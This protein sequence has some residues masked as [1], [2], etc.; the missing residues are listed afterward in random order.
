MNDHNRKE[1][2]LFISELNK[3]G[4]SYSYEIIK[5]EDIKDSIYDG[6]HGYEDM[7]NVEDIVILKTEDHIETDNNVKF[8]IIESYKEVINDLKFGTPSFSYVVDNIENSNISHY[9]LDDISVKQY[10]TISEAAAKIIENFE[11]QMFQRYMTL[12]I[13]DNKK[14]NSTHNQLREIC[15]AD[16]LINKFNKTGKELFKTEIDADNLK[17]MAY[18]KKYNNW[19]EI[20][21]I[22]DFNISTQ[23]VS[24]LSENY[25]LYINEITDLAAYNA[26][27]LN[28]KTNKSKNTI[29]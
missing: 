1:I 8:L 7:P 9:Q 5:Q 15:I 6:I 12:D 13:F 29:A 24:F 26:K 4:L 27:N 21:H 25:P 11:N 10:Q 19:A 22:E 14:T 20:S 28:I 16:S 18:C 2:D 3:N 23:T 17:L